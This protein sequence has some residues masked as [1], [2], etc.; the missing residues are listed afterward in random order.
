[1]EAIGG[2]VEAVVFDLLFTLALNQDALQGV[3][4]R[5][6]RADPEAVGAWQRAYN[7]CLSARRLGSSG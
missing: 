2:R 5:V 1:V 7:R 4:E 6:G 3:S